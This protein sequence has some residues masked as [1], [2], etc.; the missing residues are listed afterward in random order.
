M[1]R[2]PAAAELADRRAA[3]GTGRADGAD[4]ARTPGWPRRWPGWPTRSRAPPARPRLGWP[5]RR[6]DDRPAIRSA[7][8]TP[9]RRLRSSP[10]LPSWRRAA[11]GLPGR[12]ARRHRR[13]GGPRAL[14]RQAVDDLEALKRIE[15]ELEAQGYLARNERQARAHRRRPFAGSATPRCAR[16]SPSSRGRLRR[17][18]PA[19]RGPGRRPHRLA[20]GRGG[21]AT[22]SR[23]T[24]RRR[25]QRPATRRVPGLAARHRPGGGADRGE[26]RRSTT[27]RWPRPSGVRPPRSACW[28]TCPTRW[29]CAAPGPRPSRPRWRC[30]R[31]ST[32]SSRRTP[33]RSSGSPTTRETARD[34]ARRPRLG[35]GAGHQPASRPRARRRFLDRRPDYNPVVLIITD[36]EPTAHLRR[37]GVP[38]STGRLRQRRWSSRWPRSTR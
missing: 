15:R 17:S 11:P 1:R 26:A 36:G 12:A 33:C 37:D 34:R 28:S 7:S 13:G 30:T 22:S 10:T 16:C 23:S 14:G 35:H 27:S 32:R 31:W 6:A 2:R 18:R 19:R 9:R 21:S 24:P 8:A 3:R 4:P 29:P 5:A 25:S 20:R 38:S